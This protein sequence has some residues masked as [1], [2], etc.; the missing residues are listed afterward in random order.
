MSAASSARTTVHGFDEF[1]GNLYH[2][3]AEEEPECPDYPK[4]SEYPNFRKNFGPRGVLHCFAKPDGTQT[5]ED[6]GPL[7]T[8][9]METMDEEITAGALDFI[10]R[11]TKADKP[12]SAGGTLPGC[13]SLR[14]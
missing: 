8:K 1:F 9:R 11:Q 5:I 6:T 4:P 7:D 14:T 12:S 13:M 2:L 3:N 10:E